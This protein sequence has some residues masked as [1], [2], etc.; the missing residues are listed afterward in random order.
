[1]KDCEHKNVWR[2]KVG[3]CVRRKTQCPGGGG[4]LG[5]AAGR[6]G[7]TWRHA[8]G[9]AWG[10]A[11]AWGPWRSWSEMREIHRYLRFG[12]VSLQQR[13]EAAKGAAGQP[14]SPCQGLPG[15]HV[16]T[17]WGLCRVGV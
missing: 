15:H 13:P 7:G 3:R 16:Q 9:A 6:T 2:I 4:G 12:K 5:Q 17:V 14:R 8:V 1:M 10:V 11:G